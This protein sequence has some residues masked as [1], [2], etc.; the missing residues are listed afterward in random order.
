[1][2]IEGVDDKKNVYVSI[3]WSNERLKCK[4]RF[5]F[6]LFSLFPEDYDISIEELARY[7]MGIDEF[8]TITCLE[9]MRNKVR[10]MINNLKDSYLLLESNRETH[11][12]MRDMVSDVALWI[13]SK[14]E[15][16][17]TLRVCTRLEERKL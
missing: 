9:E 7:M 4:T 2:D 15:N 13:V 8:G 12:K 17:F 14:G 11:V 1:M 3:K 16:E 6:L 10:V 5:C